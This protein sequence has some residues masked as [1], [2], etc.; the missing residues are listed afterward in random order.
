MSASVIKGG[1][2]VDPSTR[3]D[4]VAD[5]YVRDGVIASIGVKPAG[6]PEGA[7]VLD[8]KGC[9]VAP[10]FIDLH[11]HLR[12][13]GQEGK[14]TIA[15]GARAALAGGFTRVCCMAN[16]QPVNDTALITSWK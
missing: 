16:T 8:A 4:R 10:G 11:V 6:F 7:E 5:L 15:S 12:E 14:E 1:R 2:V 3:V 9:I 13:P